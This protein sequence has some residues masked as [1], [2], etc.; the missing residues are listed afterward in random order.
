MVLLRLPDTGLWLVV[1]T[2][3]VNGYPII[4]LN[5]TGLIM[6]GF[7]L[8]TTLTFSSNRVCMVYNNLIP[9]FKFILFVAKTNK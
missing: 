5:S 1:T 9:A 8:I 2:A 6:I 4:V 3:V 7:L